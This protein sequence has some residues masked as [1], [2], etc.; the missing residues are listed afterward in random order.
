[1]FW[2]IFS[3]KIKEDKN[4][5]YKE[6]SEALM[7]INECKSK[8][9]KRTIKKILEN[10]DFMESLF[11]PKPSPTITEEIN[12]L[13]EE[14]TKNKCIE[15]INVFIEKYGVKDLNR[16]HATFFYSIANLSLQK[17]NE[18]LNKFAAEKKSDKISNKDYEKLSEKIKENNKNIIKLLSNLKFIIRGE[19]KDISKKTNIPKYICITALHSVPETELIDRFK[20]GF[21]LNNLLNLVYSEIESK[22]EFNKAPNWKRFFK[23]LFGEEGVVEAATFI[24]LEGVH[25]IDKYKGSSSVIECWNSLTDFALKELDEAPDSIRNQMIELYIKRIA[26]MFANGKFDLRVDLL[27]IDKSIFSKLGS[28]IE[29]Y[30]DKI[31]AILSE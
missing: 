28:S 10:K 4:L 5:D 25:R 18:K 1:M 23:F 14:I 29:N 3:N 22:G 8:K 13:Y 17:N 11:K 21:Y 20:I 7:K 2:E 9:P 19:A 30:S 31:K 24:L 26:K 15:A 16:T 6:V 27:S 12:T